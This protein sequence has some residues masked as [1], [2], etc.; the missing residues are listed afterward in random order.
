MG[1]LDN[2]VAVVTGATRG[3]GE[4]IAARFLE[5]GAAVVSVGRTAPSRECGAEH[6]GARCK[7]RH[8]RVQADVC[9]EQ[10]WERVL[11]LAADAFGGVDVLV[12]NAGRI[13]YEP[14][15]ELSLEAW[16]EIVR[17]NQTGP[18]LGMRAVVPHMRSRGRGSIVNISSIWGVAAVAGAHT[19]HA[20]KGAVRMMTKNAAITYAGT[21]IRV[22]SLMPGFIDT[23]LTEAQDPGVNDY[24]VSQTP[25]GRAGSPHEIAAGALF[26]ASDES[27]FMTG[28]DLVIDGG[29][30]AR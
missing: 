28:S 12:N 27:S 1:R 5:E 13:A 23:P 2:K 21:G 8:L 10:D 30:L 4:A 7:Q 15:D 19:Y 20:T 26:L 14:M 6:A 17:T 29:Y 9:S 25:L 3:I 11:G 24:V 16:E 18:W 22:N